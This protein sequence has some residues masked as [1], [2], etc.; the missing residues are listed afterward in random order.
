VKRGVLVV[1]TAAIGLT[2][3]AAAPANDAREPTAR[4]AQELLS[5]VCKN[6]IGIGNGGAFCKPCPK[7]VSA[8]SGAGLDESFV[9]NTVL[10]GKFFNSR[11]TH[12]L[13]DFRG[14]EAHA[15]NF[16]GT[17]ILRWE[18]LTNWSFVRYEPGNRTDDCLK[19]RARDGYDL[20]VCRGYYAHMGFEIE[21]FG[22]LNYA[23]K[24][25][26]AN[27]VTLTSNGGQCMNP[28][29]NRF[30]VQ[31]VERR[32]LNRDGRPDLRVVVGES[33]YTAPKSFRCGD[34]V[35]W[36]P[37]ERLTLD[38]VFDGLNFKPTPTTVPLVKYLGGFRA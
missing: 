27:L 22:V 5:A 36:G 8:A 4:Q 24:A 9:L 30:E 33:H 13:L 20:L 26:D 37:V 29:F 18:G 38:F 19:Y 17:V 10:F 14:C 2:A 21:G 31:G 25:G 12:A 1:F 6:Q 7:F 32:D 35:V 28:K 11:Q 16:G 3:G 15:N 34:P 23:R